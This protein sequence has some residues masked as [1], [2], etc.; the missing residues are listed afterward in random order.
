MITVSTI[1]KYHD[2]YLD[3]MTTVSSMRNYHDPLQDKIIT[4]STMRNYHDLS[5]LTWLMCLG[6]NKN[7]QVSGFTWQPA[8]LQTQ[9]FVAYS[10][11]KLYGLEYDN[12]NIGHI[13][14]LFQ[15]FTVQRW[16][17]STWNQGDSPQDWDRNNCRTVHWW[18]PK[19]LQFPQYFICL[20]SYGQLAWEC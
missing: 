11:N 19:F 4:V 7:P 10:S 2:P 5:W 13:F 18:Q 16:S 1:R 14:S 6:C 15:A 9:Y 12:K 3:N 8:A 17:Q 20:L